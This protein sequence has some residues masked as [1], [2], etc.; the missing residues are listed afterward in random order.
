VTGKTVRFTD[1]SAEDFDGIV[2]GTGYHL[3]LPFL[4]DDLRRTL[5]IDAQHIDLYNFTFHPEL[6]G[7]AFVGM[8]EQIGPY[9]P[10]LELQARWIAYTMSGAVAVPSQEELEAGVAAYRARRGTPQIVFTDTMATLFARAAGVE[11]ELE[12]WPDLARPLMFGP[13]TPMSFCMSGRDS[14]PDAPQRFAADVQAFGCIPSNQ[15]APMQI[16]QLQ[17]L[18]GA[19][20]DEA[21]SQYV[22]AVCPRAETAAG[23]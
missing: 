15:L 2:F 14:L 9:Y 16:G 19:R 17:A 8:Y 12:R 7:L 13:L 3:H 1:G 4:S 11:P 18:A 22:A 6:R 10:V 23:N 20:G 5:D 21:F